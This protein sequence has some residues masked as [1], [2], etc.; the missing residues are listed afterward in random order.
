MADILDLDATGQLAALSSQRI[1]ALDLLEAAVAR[2]EQVEPAVNALAAR[3]LDRARARARTLDDQ[4]VRNEPAGRLFGLPMTI[5]D[6]LDVDGMP[7]SAGIRKNLNRLA[8]DAAAV[9]RVRAQGA[10]IWAKTNV[11]PNASDWQ[12]FNDVYGATNNPWDLARTAGGSSGGAAAALACRV[13]ALELGSDNAGS[14]R[15]PAS[16]C[17]V[18]SHQPTYGLVPQRGHVPPEPGSLSEPDLNVIGPMARSV[19]DLRLLLSVVAGGQVPLEGRPESLQDLKVA[20]WLDDPAFY[21]DGAVKAELERFAAALGPE[22]A[23]VQPVNSPI[24]GEELLEVYAWLLYSLPTGG[25]GSW[26]KLKN[27]LKRPLA[28]FAMAHGASPQSW[29]LC[30]LAAS[31]RHDEWL[32]AD[33]A[34]AEFRRRMKSFFERWDVLVTPAAP[35]PAFPHDRRPKAKRTLKAADGSSVAYDAMVHWS[36]LST[37]CGLPAITLPVGLV[38]GLPVGVQLIGPRDGDARLLAIAQGIEERLGGYQPPPGF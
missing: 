11:A 1:S 38:N 14:L 31:A 21:I 5:K 30:T 9:A 15:A 17:G 35:V 33:E 16:F 20:L 24:D 10:V 2:A 36:A 34:R 26:T 6:V 18:L 3:D 22:G 13:T 28:R 32:E 12:T 8:G 27:E 7:A 4:R 37:V 29:A 19:R 23:K 25:S